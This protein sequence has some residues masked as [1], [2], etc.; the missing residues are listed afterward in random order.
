MFFLA[1]AFHAFLLF[2]TTPIPSASYSYGTIIVINQLSTNYQP[3]IKMFSFSLQAS[4]HYHTTDQ[5]G[6]DEL[7]TVTENKTRA[8]PSRRLCAIRTHQRAGSGMTE[9]GRRFS[10]RV[11]L[12]GLQGYGSGWTASGKRYSARLANRNEKTTNTNTISSTCPF[13]FSSILLSPQRQRRRRQRQRRQLQS[14]NVTIAASHEPQDFNADSTTTDADGEGGP[15]SLRSD[16]GDTV[17]LDGDLTESHSIEAADDTVD[18]DGD[19]TTVQMDIPVQRDLESIDL[20]NARL[21]KLN[22]NSDGSVCHSK[23]GWVSMESGKRRKLNHSKAG[24]VSMGSGKRRKLNACSQNDDKRSTQS[25]P[26]AFG[27]GAGPKYDP[28]YNLGARCLSKANG[29]KRYKASRHV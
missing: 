5:T 8:V 2:V 6:G 20:T 10:W 21:T 1:P 28:R 25:N 26:F 19:L 23:A 16:T 15:P 7:F 18:F 3:I 13:L 24:W 17:G 12:G 29:N 27:R 11:A 9:S 14:P 22:N 4:I